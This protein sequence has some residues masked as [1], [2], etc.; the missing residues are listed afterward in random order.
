MKL[1]STLLLMNVCTIHGVSNKFMDELLTFFHKYLLPKNN[2]LPL[3]MYTT[4]SLVRKVGL[5]YK[6]IHACAFHGCILFRKQYETLEACLKCEA[7]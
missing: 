1:T 7:I 3:N 4:K 6:H 5:D 2:L